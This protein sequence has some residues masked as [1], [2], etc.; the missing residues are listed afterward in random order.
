MGK[1]AAVSDHRRRVG[2]RQIQ[3]VGGKGGRASRQKGDRF[4]RECVHL[5]L[6]RGVLC[7]R[8]PL[9]GAAGGSFGSDLRVVIQGTAK[10]VECK[11][12]QRAWADLYQW[13][14]GNFAL[15][16]RSNGRKPLVVMPLDTFADL[17][18]E[19]W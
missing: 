5:L 11:I 2:R 15:F 4:E 8:V 3:K 12:R 17:H 6:G 1:A 7:E 10:Q 19:K 13:L 16:I 14:E 9:S 18:G